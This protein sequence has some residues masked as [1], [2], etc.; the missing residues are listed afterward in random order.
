MAKVIKYAPE[1]DGDE[2]LYVARLMKEMTEAQAEHFAK[3]YRERRKNPE[4]I[5]F[6]DLAGL[7]GIAGIHR[8]LLD[9]IFVG[10]IYL[11]TAGFC[12]IGTIVDLFMHKQLTARY[13][14][15]KADEVA[16]LIVQVIDQPR[17]EGPEEDL[18]D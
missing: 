3:M 13:N 5:L 8:F 18:F 11:F 4:L 12:G 10:L 15:K 2:Q 6:A 16:A 17:L 1:L 7:L 14:Q 9:Q